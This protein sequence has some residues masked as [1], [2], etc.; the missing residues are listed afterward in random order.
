MLLD[1][2]VQH[3]LWILFDRPGLEWYNPGIHQALASRS[4]DLDFNTKLNQYTKRT[5]MLV[6]GPSGVGKDTLLDRLEVRCSGI[7]RCVTYTTRAPRPKETPGRD[8][9]S[10]T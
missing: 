5:G 9:N 8:Y 3:K 4:T 1:T 7:E 6:V 2:H 10:S